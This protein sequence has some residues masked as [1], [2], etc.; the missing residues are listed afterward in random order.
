MRTF[1]YLASWTLRDVILSTPQSKKE[2]L[3]LIVKYPHRFMMGSDVVGRFRNTG[4][5]LS[6]W[7]EI[8]DSLPPEVAENMAKKNMLQVVK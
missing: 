7:D 6:G 5:V 4:K 2:W 3:A 8:L 1:I